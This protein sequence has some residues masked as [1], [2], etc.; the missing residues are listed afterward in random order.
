M[1]RWTLGG[2]VQASSGT[3]G[4][5]TDVAVRHISRWTGQAV[6]DDCPCIAASYTDYFV[7]SAA[8]EEGCEAP[9]LQLHRDPTPWLPGRPVFPGEPRVPRPDDYLDT[10][11]RT[12]GGTDR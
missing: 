7:A 10:V 2:T 4:L 12:G 5:P 9:E 3:I 11:P 8:P 1:R 6:T